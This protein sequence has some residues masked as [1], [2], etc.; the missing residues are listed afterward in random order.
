MCYGTKFVKKPSQEKK[1]ILMD[2][3]ARVLG[4]AD[5]PAGNVKSYW[6]DACEDI[7]C[8]DFIHNFVDF[9]SVPGAALVPEP[10]CATSNQD[11]GSFSASEPVCNISN[12]DAN[13]LD[14]P[15]F[16][17]GIEQILDS[18]KNGK[19]LPS[20][21]GGGLN[22]CSSMVSN[23]HSVLDSKVTASNIS[24]YNH[25]DDQNDTHSIIP[26]AAAGVSVK[27]IKSEG[28]RP[29]DCKENRRR[30]GRDHDS[31]TADKD[32]GNTKRVCPAEVKA[33]N[34]GHQ[35]SL[36]R[37][38]SCDW[39]VL[40]SD[41]CQRNQVRRREQHYGSS[42]KDRDWKETKGYWERDREKNEMVYRLGSWEAD[43][44]CEIPAEKNLQSNAGMRKK[45]EE[46]KE[47][48][49]LPEEQARQYQLDVLEQAK[50]KNT[51][52]FLETGAGKTL[53]AILLIKS[54]STEMQ[55]QNKKMLAV[56]LVP[57]VPLVYQVMFHCQIFA[58]IHLLLSC[59]RLFYFIFIHFAA[60]RS[61]S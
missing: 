36:C 31:L 11:D 5:F 21:C 56:F 20:H 26:K 60:S 49:K 40:D 22:H 27:N 61:N 33:E 45:A 28:D 19:G 34:R 46:E 48:V 7:S 29:S 47:T 50:K 4:R 14:D 57:K 35:R 10:A 25:Y 39:D 30:H 8:D 6:L 3:E 38:R 55:R 24:W 53:I 2:D 32:Y 13:S 17:G 1:K 15:C 52:A 12:Q 59:L 51:I 23:E 41:S 54:I 44:D 42:R 37:K 18:I 43:R 16:F 58:S 9:S